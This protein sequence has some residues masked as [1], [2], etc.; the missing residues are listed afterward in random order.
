MNMKICQASVILLPCNPKIFEEFHHTKLL[1]LT[2][3]KILL[4]F[5]AW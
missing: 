5:V 2:E 1:C 3:Y 4:T